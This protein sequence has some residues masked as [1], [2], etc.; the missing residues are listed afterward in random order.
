MQY[1][2][3]FLG[4]ACQGLNKV[5]IAVGAR[6]KPV[7]QG[8]FNLNLNLALLIYAAKM[9]SLSLRIDCRGRKITGLL[10][11]HWFICGHNYKP[12]EVSICTHRPAI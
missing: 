10:V 7:I 8:K 5:C 1:D 2:C 6:I 11:V 9:S 4:P 12:S 3:K